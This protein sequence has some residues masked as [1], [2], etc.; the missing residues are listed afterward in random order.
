MLNRSRHPLPAT[1]R[2]YTLSELMIA[3][4][5]GV[6]ILGGLLHVYALHT[7][8]ARHLLAEARLQRALGD[9]AM[10]IT[11]ELRRAG[12]WSRAHETLDGASNGFAEI[13]LVGEDCILYSYDRD[14]DSA[15]G[16]PDDD[17]RFGLRLRAGSLQL[18]S[19]D[20]CGPSGCADCEDGVWWSMSDPSNVTLTR[21]VFALDRHQ[22]GLP[23]G[24]TVTAR[25]VRYVLEGALT[26]D[27][28]ITATIAGA[29]DVRNDEID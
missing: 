22:R 14:A 13:R 3:S 23:D 19:S 26:E 1:L 18:K 17:D 4:A 9:A 7:G 15:T 27:P 12:Y 25:S 20:S 11:G 29:A 5:I 8:A 28:G 6:F 24:R 10:L 16:V 21:L 2:G